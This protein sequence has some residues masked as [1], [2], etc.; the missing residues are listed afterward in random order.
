MD[1]KADLLGGPLAAYMQARLNK[2][3]VGFYNSES[4]PVEKEK[5]SFHNQ[6]LK[7]TQDV[8]DI[9]SSV[10]FDQV[11]KRSPRQAL[12]YIMS[13]IHFPASR[14]CMTKWV[15]EDVDVYLLENG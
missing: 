5:W 12:T 15:Q 2:T 10:M 1:K 3:I 4:D 7:N 9:I 6:Y 8:C 13:Y 11:L 14:M